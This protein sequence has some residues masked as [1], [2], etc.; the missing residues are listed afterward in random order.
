MDGNLIEI[1]Q[2]GKGTLKD[3]QVEVVP[4]A[5]TSQAAD[6]Q[7]DL[8]VTIRKGEPVSS[9]M[10]ASIRSE[11]GEVTDTD[12]DF[13]IIAWKEAGAER[14]ELSYRDSFSFA[15]PAVR[16]VMVVGARPPGRTYEK[17]PL[18]SAGTALAEDIQI[19]AQDI[20]IGRIIL[21]NMEA[22]VVLDPDAM[23]VNIPEVLFV[24]RN[25]E[26]RLQAALLPPAEGEIHRHPVDFRVDRLAVTGD[27]QFACIDESTNPVFSERFRINMAGIQ[28]L[29]IAGAL[30]QVTAVAD[31]EGENGAKLH[32]DTGL[33]PVEDSSS[34][35]VWNTVSDYPA[36]SLSPYTRTM[37]G[38][39]IMSGRLTAETSIASADDQLSGEM[40]LQLR[41]IELVPSASPS[42]AGIDALAVMPLDSAM[43]YLVDANG[44][45]EILVPVTGE[46]HDP[47]QIA[48]RLFHHLLPAAIRSAAYRI[49]QKEILSFHALV[50]PGEDPAVYDGK[51]IAGLRL[52]PVVLDPGEVLPGKNGDEYTR[53]LSELLKKDSRLRI[54]IIGVSTPRDRKAVQMDKEETGKGNTVL[55]LLAR[56]RAD[57]FREILVLHYGVP[58]SRIAGCRSRVDTGKGDIRPRIEII[59]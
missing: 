53:E 41:G 11:G 56:E 23:P 24:E 1:T 40:L 59:M 31:L 32:L 45:G 16:A 54:K 5:V 6:F 55:S 20:R 48:S 44:D 35:T 46:R 2:K 39:D 26:R 18:L 57:T 29:N 30:R 17:Y 25:E 33:V 4:Y 38:V 3:F 36:A 14:V 21:D 15:S 49:V 34:L 12:T 10:V 52:D 13:M 42:G 8:L 37:W 28:S 51:L 58:A 19:S 27:S 9:R 7:T 22:V 43:G 47:V 50:P